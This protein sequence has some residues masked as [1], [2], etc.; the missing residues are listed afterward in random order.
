[1]DDE[2]SSCILD[3]IPESERSVSVKTLDFEHL[4]VDRALGVLW[5]VE[6]DTLG[7]EILVKQRPPSRRG[8]LSVVSSIYDPLGFASPC[9][10]QAKILLQDLCKKKLQWDDVISP[11]DL[12]NGSRGCKTSLS[13]SH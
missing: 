5:D 13:Y 1:M 2:Q 6:T 7:F 4:P 10:L 9:I 12:E 3:S 8:I 11:E